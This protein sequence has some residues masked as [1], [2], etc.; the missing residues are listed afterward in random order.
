MEHADPHVAA[1]FD[2]LHANQEG[3]FGDHLFAECKV[4][5]NSLGRAVVVEVEQAWVILFHVFQIVSSLSHRFSAMPRWRGLYH[6]DKVF[7]MKFND[8]SKEED[9]S[10]VRIHLIL[11][12]IITT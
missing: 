8:G 10:K 6:F 4:V 5:L 3:M 12:S 11:V 7:E 9:I 2:R 1:C